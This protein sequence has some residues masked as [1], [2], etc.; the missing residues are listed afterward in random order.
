[1]KK[2]ISFIAISVLLFNT[3]GS[4]IVFKSM[5]YC[6]HKE[7]KN[8]ITQ[9]IPQ[10]K[11]IT[12]IIDKNNNKDINFVDDKEFMYKGKMYDVV[13]QQANGNTTIYYCINDTKEEELYAN[14]NKEMKTNM[15]TNPVKN[16]TKHI[17][18][19][20]TISLF[21]EDIKNTHTNIAYNITYPIDYIVSINHLYDVITPPPKTV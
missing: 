7:I 19:K 11:L 20:I 3:I 16:K 5:S 1:M 15:D 4:L 8:A 2:L 18:N 10:N 12:I 14:L 13:R 17:L 6:I 21:Y 9:S